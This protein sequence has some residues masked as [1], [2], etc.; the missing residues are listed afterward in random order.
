MNHEAVC[1]TAPATLGLLI[2]I[3]KFIISKIKALHST[4]KQFVI[5]EVTEISPVLSSERARG[6]LASST[7]ARYACYKIYF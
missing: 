3:M 6:L 2:M 5:C 7:F 4:T 1:R